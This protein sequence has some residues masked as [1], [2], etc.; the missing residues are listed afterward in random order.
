LE[1]ERTD[2]LT[3]FV[4]REIEA[5]LEDLLESL[6]QAQK[7]G[8]GGG[9]GG[10]GKQP[11]LRK[12]AELKMLRAAQMR[13]N[14]RTKQFEVIRGDAELDPALETEI[15]NIGDRQSE[16]T[17]MAAEVMEKDN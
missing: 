7:E 17:D 2:Q 11:L 9:G 5:A 1:D 6:K 3:Q 12:S 16:I 13:V 10:G 4:Q 8:G 14:R 15:Q